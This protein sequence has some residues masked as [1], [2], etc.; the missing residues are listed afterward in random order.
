[1]AFSTNT[2]SINETLWS[3]YASAPAANR[4]LSVTGGRSD[5]DP[6]TIRGAGFGVGG[7]IA[8]INYETHANFT[9]P[10]QA[11]SS[12]DNVY[13]MKESDNSLSV[14]GGRSHGYCVEGYGT[15][16]GG[17]NYSAA[18]NKMTLTGNPTEVFISYWVKNPIGK[19]MP[20]AD[21]NTVA[22]T[23]AVGSN[24][25][26]IWPMG[27]GS[28]INDMVCPTLL[29][30]GHMA[31]SG[32]DLYLFDSPLDQNDPAFW[33]FGEWVN[34][35]FWL[36]AGPVANIDPCDY[37]AHC[38]SASGGN[39]TETVPDLTALFEYADNPPGHFERLSCPGWMREQASVDN[40]TLDEVSFLYDDV[41]VS[42]GAGS[43]ARI[44]LSNNANIFAASER[45]LCRIVGW[46]DEVV[47]IVL[48]QSAMNFTGDVFMHLFDRDN[49]IIDTRQIL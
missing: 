30:N 7:D 12:V 32:N 9:A 17:A 16:D 3:A 6:L 27:A 41:Y 25:K 10:G 23:W 1:M 39:Y 8:K 36:K 49:N 24:L 4:I 35:S 44:D 45:S 15:G 37:A 33:T 48:E 11:I 31:V 42:W 19:K 29:S 21:T 34:F 20:N 2:Q 43:A 38:M 28:G 13:D 26:F 5:G 22:N 18:I 14:A 40:D 47:A 46:D